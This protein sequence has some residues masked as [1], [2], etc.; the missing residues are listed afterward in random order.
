VAHDDYQGGDLTEKLRHT[1]DQV[2]VIAQIEMAEAV[3]N[4]EEMAAVEGI[5]ALWI[6]QFDLTVSQGI[7]AE[8]DHPDFLRATRRVVEA[9]RRHGKA[10]VLGAMDVEILCRGPA[11]G[12]RMLVYLADI[13][14]YQQALRRG[15]G[16]IRE[17][18]ALSGEGKP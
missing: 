10:A 16:T 17:C 5:D 4:V 2:L 8:F 1:D 9:C 6:G 12:F 7:P 13:W 18:L 11:E 3:A 14:I 15:M